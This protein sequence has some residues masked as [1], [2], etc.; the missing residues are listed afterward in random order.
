MNI[1]E[2]TISTPW[3]AVNEILCFATTPIVRLLIIFWDISIGFR[4]KFYGFPR[5]Q[6][7]K[8]SKILIG[9]RFECRSAK[10]SNPLGLNHATIIC[11]WSRGAQIIIGDDVG[12][13]GVS[14]VSNNK[15]VIGSGTIIGANCTIID[16]D[17]HPVKSNSRRYDKENIKTLPVVI[18]KNVFVGM[19]SIIL[20]GS[21]IPD[22][23][24]V[25]AGSVVRGVFK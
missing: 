16:T 19:N 6:K 14:I 9:D 22:N 13:S 2:Q 4:P 10:Y 8:G 25:P 23:S 3:K 18:G 1:F 20:K 24:I 11:T 5:F 12:V 7:H 21:T 17:F 15:V